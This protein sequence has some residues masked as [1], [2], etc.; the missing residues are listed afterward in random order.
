MV[1]A[2]KR[3]YVLDYLLP[4]TPDTLKTGYTAKQLQICYDHEA[5]I[6]NFFVQ[7]G[8]LLYVTDPGQTKDYMADGPKTEVFG[9]DSPGF[10]GQFVGWQ[11]V[12]KWMQQD[13]KRTLET[14]LQTPPGEIFQQA[15]YKPR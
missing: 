3:M 10:I 9:D 1:E 5:Q 7:N 8:N 12:K 15:K 14:L 11:I 13:D 6:W 4:D 2:G